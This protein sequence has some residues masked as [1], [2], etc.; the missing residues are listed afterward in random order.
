M[1]NMNKIQNLSFETYRQAYTVGAKSQEVTHNTIV[2]TTDA[3]MKFYNL[4]F[5]CH[6]I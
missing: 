1:H 6:G 5:N 2:V 4:P 3:E